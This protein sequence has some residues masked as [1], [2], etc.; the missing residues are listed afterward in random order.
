M[1]ETEHKHWSEWLADRIIEEKKEPYIITAGI[2]TSGPAHL[3]TLCEFLFPNAIKKQLE[4]KG[5]QATFYFLADILDAFDSVPV[6]M[7]KYSKELEPHLGK[8]LCFVPDPTGKSK[9]F[10]D[11]FLDEVR[12][13]MG[14][15]GV[16]A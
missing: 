13:L 7:E 8:P 10:G 6:A 11:Y 4:K 15:F 1:N 2:T 14:L 5:K 16:H 3:G 12:G 9:S